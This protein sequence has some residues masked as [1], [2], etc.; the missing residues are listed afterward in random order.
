[1]PEM[2]QANLQGQQLE[3][4][5]KQ[6]PTST[7]ISPFGWALITLLFV[8]GAINFS[9]K[10]VPGLAAVPIIKELRLSPAQYGLVSGSL[11]WL[12]SLSPALLILGAIFLYL[13]VSMPSTLEAV[14][15]FTLAGTAGA[16]IPLLV[17][18]VLDVTPQAHRGFFQGIVVALATLLGFS[19]SLVTRVMLQASL[20]L[21]NA[22]VLAPLLLIVGGVG[23]TAC[24]RPGEA[25]ARASLAP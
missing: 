4:R 24:A 5:E 8:L 23:L 17:A 1:M 19:A 20:G 2:P 12:F 10:A 18:I 3:E 16:A 25:S 14:T 21:Y 15:L 11:I 13:A 6:G 7:R 22:Y 9:D